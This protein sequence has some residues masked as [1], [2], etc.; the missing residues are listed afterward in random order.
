[1]FLGNHQ[2]MSRTSITAILS[3]GLIFTTTVRADV[4]LLWVPLD[5]LF[6]LQGHAQDFRDRSGDTAVGR[7]TIPLILPQ[8]I[9]RGSLLLLILAWTYGLVLLWHPPMFAG[10][11]FTFLGV[12]SA[13]KF[14]TNYSEEEDRKSFNWYSVRGILCLSS[15]RINFDGLAQLW[16]IC[17]HVLPIFERMSSREIFS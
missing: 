11:I 3:S 14:V 9:A 13:A 10:C 17:A 12:T 5:S 1:M 7:R 2:A 6:F 4:S 16:L 15:P 8:G